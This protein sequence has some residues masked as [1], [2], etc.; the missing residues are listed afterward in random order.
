ME[1]IKY[2]KTV[3]FEGR[4]GFFKQS[5]MFVQRSGT[6]DRIQLFPM[7]SRGDIGRGMMEIPAAD[8]ELFIQALQDAAL[9]LRKPEGV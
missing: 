2:G 4:N 8:V 9:K 7:T 5:G 6:E 1:K 3:N